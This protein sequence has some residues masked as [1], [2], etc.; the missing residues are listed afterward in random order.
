VAEHDWHQGFRLE[1]P[2]GIERLSHPAMLRM[3][4]APFAMCAAHAAE[5]GIDP[6]RIGI[7]GF[8]PADT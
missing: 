4:N 6:Q 1:I 7:I 3:R 8:P 2:A 5:L